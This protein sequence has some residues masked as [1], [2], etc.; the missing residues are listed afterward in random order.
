MWTWEEFLAVTLIHR[1]KGQH[2]R[3]NYTL[4]EI[5]NS[6]NPEIIYINPRRRK[7]KLWPQSLTGGFHPKPKK[8]THSSTLRQAPGITVPGV[9]WVE[10]SWPWPLLLTKCCWALMRWDPGSRFWGF[11][12]KITWLCWLHFKQLPIC[13]KKAQFF[14]G[15][16]TQCYTNCTGGR[17]GLKSDFFWWNLKLGALIKRLDVKDVDS[18]EKALG[19]CVRKLLFSKIV[20]V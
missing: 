19:Q 11:L 13:L 16:V 5:P 3:G 15:I 4:E 9:K 18:A 1:F 12:C 14:G 8:A 6:L 17:T 20:L 2:L 10:P 7:K